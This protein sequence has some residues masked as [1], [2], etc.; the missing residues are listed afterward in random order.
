MKNRMIAS[1]LFGALLSSAAGAQ[2][3]YFSAGGPI[4]DGGIGSDQYGPAKVMTVTSNAANPIQ[5][6][7]LS[8]TMSHEYVGDLRVRLTYSPTGSSTIFTTIVVDRVGAPD[9]NGYGS[10]NTINGTFAFA[11]GMTSFNSAAG[12]FNNLTYGVFAPFKN[13]FNGSTQVVE[14]A[15]VFRGLPGGGVWSL[16]FDDGAQQYVG[17][18]TSASIGIEARTPPCLADFNTDGVVNTAD[19]TSFLAKFGQACQ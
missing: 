2:T 4:P 14:F 19:L 1:A 12:S 18:V 6:I 10:S 13:N 15:D 3:F 9:G 17:S 11:D 8:I 7:V 16:I 5:N